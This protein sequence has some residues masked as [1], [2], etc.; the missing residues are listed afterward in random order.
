MVDLDRDIVRTRDGEV[1]LL[2]EDEFHVHQVKYGYSSEM[3]DQA[4]RDAAELLDAVR[5]NLEPFSGSAAARRAAS[6]RRT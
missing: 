3:I 5:Q 4:T 6:I 2:D 1:L